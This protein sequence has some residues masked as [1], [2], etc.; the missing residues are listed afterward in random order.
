[1]WV[2]EEVLDKASDGSARDGD[3]LDAGAYHVPLSL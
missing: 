3:V 2:P 1:M